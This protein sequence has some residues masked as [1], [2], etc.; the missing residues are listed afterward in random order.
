MV[1]TKTND[2][3]ENVANIYNSNA[4]Q[5]AKAS[6]RELRQLTLSPSLVS[7]LGD[8]S[9]KKV[10]DIGCG[11]GLSCEL[12]ISCNAEKVVGIDISEK[13]IDIAKK[14]NLK[15]T[16]YFVRNAVN[17]LTDLGKFDLVTAI[18]SVHY[19]HSE[20]ILKK[21]FT[22]I[23]RVLSPNGEFLAV[24]VPFANYE[25]YGVKISSP[26]NEE[27]ELSMVSVSDF[28]GNNYLEFDDIYWSQ[29]TYQKILQ[30]IGF[31]LTWLP[32]FVSPEGIKK[33]GKLFWKEFQRKP[34]YKIF[35]AK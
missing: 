24:V 11:T 15:R 30:S 23:Q 29:S 33:F 26:S 8:L 22:N 18:L 10:L 21:C 13:E 4:E 32:C 6:K 28:S 31:Q 14:T 25:G 3:F 7:H 35:R 5:Y 20:A 2:M 17:D 27:G 12:L 16:S 34:L 9:R 1:T 19:C